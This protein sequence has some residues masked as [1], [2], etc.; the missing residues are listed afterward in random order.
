M[1]VKLRLRRQ[2]RK[3]APF[4]HVVVADSR[5]PRDGRFIEKLG[6]YNPM[7]KPATIEI[8]RERAY[9]WVSVGAQPTNTVNAILRFTGVNLKKHLQ[10]GVSKGAITQEIADQRLAEWTDSKTTKIA[11]RKVKTAEEM[12]AKN[13]AVFGKPKEKKV[14]VVEEPQAEEVVEEVVE[15]ATEEAPAVEA[16][17]EEVVVEAP[18]A[19]APAVEAVVEE[20][21][22]AEAPTEEAPAAETT[23]N[24]E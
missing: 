23:E 18:V 15:A 13:A 5:S 17:V 7:T 9:Y 16:V 19:E 3:G 2:G 10:L 14:V 22:V 11:D 8:D 21:P 6:T 24:P 20:A 1:A 12:A 4:Y